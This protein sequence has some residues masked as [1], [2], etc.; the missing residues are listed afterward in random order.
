MVFIRSRRRHCPDRD[1]DRSLAHRDEP[2]PRQLHVP[3][4]SSDSRYHLTGRVAMTCQPLVRDDNACRR[5]C[6]RCDNHLQR[7][8]Q[9]EPLPFEAR[10]PPERTR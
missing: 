9:G 10:G 7:A 6:D 5:S 2:E 8:H 4:H 3:L 1:A